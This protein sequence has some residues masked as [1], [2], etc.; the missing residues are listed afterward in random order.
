MAEPGLVT[1]LL[2]RVS[3]GDGAAEDELYSLVEPELMNIARS[4]LKG[5]QQGGVETK[6]LAEEVFLQLVKRAQTTW[7]HRGQFY[8]YAVRKSSDLLVDLI[9]HRYAKK[10][11]GSHVRVELE[12]NQLPNPPQGEEAEAGVRLDVHVALGKLQERSPEAA[13]V[14]RLRYYWSF[15]FNEI[16][17]VLG[18]PLTTVRNRLD[19]A[20]A[21]LRRE[22]RDYVPSV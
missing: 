17:E 12:P 16:A 9:R 8:A 3:Q 20:L 11:E 15:Q 18:F 21:F 2:H 5:Q 22:L 10:R 1:E 7:E 4:A 14:F 6:V 13:T 19:F